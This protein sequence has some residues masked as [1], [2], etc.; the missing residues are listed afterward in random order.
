MPA[1]WGRLILILVLT[2]AGPLAAARAP[3]VSQG[4]T[5]AAHAAR[6]TEHLRA[7]GEIRPLAL[8]V[9]RA[10]QP[11]I[12]SRLVRP[13]VRVEAGQILA[14][15]AG[16]QAQA[17]LARRRGAVRARR[18]RWVADRRQLHAQLVTRQ[19]LAADQAAYDSARSALQATLRTLT[20][21]APVGGRIVAVAVADGTQATAGETLLRLQS[22]RLWL[23][24]K[25][26]GAAAFVIHR[27]MTGSFVPVSGGPRVGVRVAAVMP[28][29]GPDGGEQVLLRLDRP[30]T[31]ATAWHGGQWGTVILDGATRTLVVVPTRALILDRARWWVLVRT[32]RGDRRQRV[33][34]GPTR[35]WLTYLERGVRAGE[36]VVV[37]NAYLEFHRGIAGHYTPPD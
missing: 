28:A 12:V 2:L 16:P 4:G 36:H 17:V 23:H 31:A 22:G 7:F 15:I 19:R 13:G 20:L 30:R 33:V 35:G 8:T 18:A 29:V 32:T 10:V 21:R 34:P 9:V 26:Y 24:A 14:V 5:V 11:G 25:F 27:G 3:G 37:Q 1:S 6:L